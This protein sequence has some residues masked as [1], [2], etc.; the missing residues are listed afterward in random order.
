MREIIFMREN[1]FMGHFKGVKKVEAEYWLLTDILCT[2]TL[3][4]AHEKNAGDLEIGHKSIGY[5]I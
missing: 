5:V 2:R 4:P 3:C 1:Y